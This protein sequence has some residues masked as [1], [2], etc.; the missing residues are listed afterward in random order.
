MRTELRGSVPLLLLFVIGLAGGV[1]IFI[2]PWAVGYPMRS[3]WT[4][5]AWTSVWAGA[6]LTTV[7][8][9]CIV[10]LLAR[11]LYVAQRGDRDPD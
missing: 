4:S 8:A 5:S 3:G 10:A 9:V 2:A 6:V 1:W 7:S 11:V